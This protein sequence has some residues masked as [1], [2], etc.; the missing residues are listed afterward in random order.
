MAQNWLIQH[1]ADDLDEG[2]AR[3][4]LS[5][6]LC[7]PREPVVHFCSLEVLDIEVQ[8]VRVAHVEIT[9]VLTTSL[10]SLDAF[11]PFESETA[12]PRVLPTI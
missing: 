11:L 10:L 1:T 2:H 4:I 5:R 6:A 8:R 3:A 12:S 7:G 9:V